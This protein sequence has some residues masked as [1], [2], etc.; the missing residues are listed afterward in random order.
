MACQSSANN[1]ILALN[2]V[3]LIMDIKNHEEFITI[4]R[5]NA[6]S[7]LFFKTKFLGMNHQTKFYAKQTGNLDALSRFKQNLGMA[8][9]DLNKTILL[10]VD[11]G[12]QAEVEE[13]FGRPMELQLWHKVPARDIYRQNDVEKLLGT[14]FIELNELPRV[15][16][17]R[18][19]N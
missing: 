9:F 1:Y 2:F 11:L 7:S 15:T 8:I 12:N 18:T 3:E 4:S 10:R 6:Q 13:A 19:K 14:F 17:A 16:N 5:Q